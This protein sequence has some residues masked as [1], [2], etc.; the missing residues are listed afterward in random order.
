MYTGCFEVL[1]SQVHLWLCETEL[2]RSMLLRTCLKPLGV[3]H[4]LIQQKYSRLPWRCFSL[5]SE[6]SFE[7]AASLL[8]LP[9]CTHDE[10]SAHLLQKFNTEQLLLSED[11][12]Q[13]LSC[14]A[15]VLQ[16]TTFT[17]ERLH[18]KNTQHARHRATHKVEV[19]DLG[20]LHAAEG[21]P[22]WLQHR[23]GQIEKS[24]RRRRKSQKGS[25]P[26][27]SRKASDNLVH[28]EATSEGTGSGAQSSGGGESA[29]CIQF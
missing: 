3:A 11:L 14:I 28:E 5:L 24:Q 27:R 21:A 13:L 22:A 15:Q 26:K 6:P 2:M 29:A 16:L 4:M 20:L 8:Q 23:L 18:A 10:F 25:A 17:T 1:H 19:S 9:A 12:R 7:N